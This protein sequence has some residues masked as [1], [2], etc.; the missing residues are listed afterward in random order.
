MAIGANVTVTYYKQNLNKYYTLGLGPWIRYYFN[1]GVFVKAETNLI[2]LHGMG[3]NNSRQRSYSIMPGVGY[4]FFLNQKVSLEP[5][6][7]YT[8]SHTHY[9]TDLNDKL[10]NLQLEAKFSIFL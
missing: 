9:S 7:S 6:L 4:A 10:N 5:C 8:Y 3:S 2:L 1:S